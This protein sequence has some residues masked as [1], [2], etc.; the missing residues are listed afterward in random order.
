[1]KKAII[2]I[3][4]IF[5][6]SL[7]LNN[8]VARPVSYSGGWTVMSYNDYYRNTLLTHYSANSKAS[9][10]YMLQ[11]WQNKKYWINAFN[12][13]YLAKRKNKK[14]SQSNFYIKGGLGVLNTNYEEYNN[15]NEI[16]SYGEFAL[17][18]ETR[19]YFTSYAASFTKSESVDSNLMQ[20]S[21][22]GFAPYIAGYGAFHTWLM[23][24][25][26]NIRENEDALI[27]NF[28]LRFFK[29]TNLLELGIDQNK[30]TTINFIK[31]F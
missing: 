28:V 15:K 16:V 21:R 29:S 17:D 20:K 5:L 31:R 12:V 4:L 26:N 7:Y 10:G 9:Y 18:W 25:L 6:L 8:S 23:Y 14:Y 30:N 27:S 13:N 24:E 11:Y 3:K 19:R 2:V 1:M 22:L